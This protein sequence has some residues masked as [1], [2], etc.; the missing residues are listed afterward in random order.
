M[1]DKVFL[2]TNIILYAISTDEIKKH[3]I[4]KPIVLGNA[5]IS[6][7]VI[8]ESSAN[9][10]RKFKFDELTIQKFVMSSYQRFEVVGLSQDI[11]IKGSQLRTHYNLSY[12]DS[13]IVAAALVSHCNILYSEDMQDG[14]IIEKKLK[15]V[16]PFK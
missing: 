15:I 13:I 3:A 1:Q 4:A 2:D 9:L 6:V 8:N 7:Q 11:F 14:L 16:N 5:T 12:Y 10:I